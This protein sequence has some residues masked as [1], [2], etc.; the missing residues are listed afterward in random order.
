VNNAVDDAALVRR[1]LAGDPQAQRALV[2]RHRALVFRVARNATGN[3]DDALDITQEAFVA[4]FTALRRFDS[5]RS[6]P[7]WI[8]RI[9]LNKCRDWSRRRNVRRFLGLPI[10]DAGAQQ[11]PDDAV[12]PDEIVAS[13]VELEMVAR[14]VALLPHKLKEALLLR[15]IEGLSQ[16]EAASVLGVSEK[17]IETRVYRAR[18]KL[19]ELL[20]DQTITRV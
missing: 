3:D 4:A 12:L 18:Q 6:F 2:E 9:T 10:S 13:R 5:E 16:A 7:A 1:S 14:A 8:S 20:R 15:A 17:T 11:I 19:G